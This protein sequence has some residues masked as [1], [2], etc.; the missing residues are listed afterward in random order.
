MADHKQIRI[1]L[2]AGHGGI[3]PFNN[4][5]VTRGKRM[6]KDGI[7]FYE[8]VNNRDNVERIYK[9]LKERGYDVIKLVD[10]WQDVP[11]RERIK[12]EHLLANDNSI[13]LSIHSDANGNGRDWNSAHGM[14]CFIY[15]G[16]VSDRTLKLADS[17]NNSL[18]CHFDGISKN[19]GIRKANFAMCRD[20][21]SPSVLLELG[22]HTNKDEVQL[23][24]TDD[25]KDRIVKSIVEAIEEYEKK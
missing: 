6:I 11:L 25:W 8:G 13:L 4:E 2:D 14:G 19:R 9:A 24:L 16:N 1:I 15:N 3:S 20:T 18:I 7:T 10:T 22:F 12:Q 17:L 5:Y 21:L 23:M